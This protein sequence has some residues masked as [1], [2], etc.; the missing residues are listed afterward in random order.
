M[1][2]KDYQLR[3]L[4]ALEKFFA[5]TRS[6]NGADKAFK[7]VTR[8]WCGFGLEYRDVAELPGL[9][10]VCLRVP[11]GGGKTIMA[12]HAAGIAMHNLLNADR[13]VVLWLV[14][15]NAIRSQ[16]LN[17]LRDRR[18][19]YRSALESRLGSVEVLDVME[20]LRLNRGTLD[21]QTVIIVATI[22]AFRVEDTEGRKVY[23]QSGALD[24]HFMRHDCGGADS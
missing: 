10:Y 1:L 22:Q 17:A 19:P 18:H 20:A 15:S 11:T 5:L 2:L 21:S 14:P 7:E 4:E 23:E 13:C 9:P 3:S 12:C 24:H 6:D 8:E 16:T